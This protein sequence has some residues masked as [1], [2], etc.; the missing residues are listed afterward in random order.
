LA[1]EFYRS[2]GRQGELDLALLDARKALYGDKANEP[3]WLSPILVVQ[4]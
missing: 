1:Q 2:L 3:S 4:G